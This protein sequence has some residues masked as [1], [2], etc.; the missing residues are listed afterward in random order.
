MVERI[1]EKWK[2]IYNLELLH[3]VEIYILNID[4]PKLAKKKSIASN[5]DKNTLHFSKLLKQLVSL[6]L[7]PSPHLPP[8]RFI[9]MKLLVFIH[10]KSPLDK[11]ETQ[12]TVRL[13]S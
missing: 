2:F 1:K 4:Y 7:S 10:K 6:S 3:N 12:G 11:S 9:C 5:N 8:P 13:H